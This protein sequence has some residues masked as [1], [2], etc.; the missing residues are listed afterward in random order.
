[1]AQGE[2]GRVM[3]GEERYRRKI[4][5][6]IDY[7]EAHLEEK[8]SLEELSREANFS[9][10]HFHRIFSAFRGEPLY[11]FISRL[12]VER[13]AALLATRSASITEIAFRVGFDDSAT[14]ARAFKKR[15]GLPAG[16]WKKAKKRKI[17]QA[18]AHPPVYPS[19]A[20]PITAQ[21]VCE[22]CC[23]ELE[24]AYVRH[25]GPF[26]GD[27]RLFTR[28]YRRLLELLEAEG[29]DWDERDGFYALYHDPAGITAAP[30][31]RLSLGIPTRSGGAGAAGSTGEGE[32]EAAGGG[33]H[34]RLPGGGGPA[35][36][37]ET[38]P[39]AG[40]LGRLR[41]SAGRYLLC[42]FA[43]HTQEYGRAWT[44]VYRRIIPQRGLEPADGYC[45]EH[46]AADC[47]DPAG[48]ITELQIAVPVQ[49]V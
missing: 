34:T 26:A 8:L 45:Y 25:T 24:L 43:L 41:L 17:D 6:I 40:R 36:P 13:A 18:P 12:R 37:R 22:R 10:Y 3:T 7:I 32:T 4:D 48:D 38:G 20:E 15:F 28:L 19:P 42:R 47:Y 11:A 35:S 46:Y 39:G 14:F 30:Q 2:R 27:E 49:E 16:E 23:P 33:A 29:V 21:E 44:E 31:L 9:P 5:Y 1:M